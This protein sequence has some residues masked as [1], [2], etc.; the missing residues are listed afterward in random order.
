LTPFIMGVMVQLSCER[1]PQYRFR[2]DALKEYVVG[3]LHAGPAGSWQDLQS[4]RA[5]LRTDESIDKLD[6]ELGIG[7]EEIVGACVLAA[8][9]RTENLE[10]MR[11]IADTAFSWTRGWIKVRTIRCTGFH[12]LISQ[13]L[14]G[15]PRST[16]A[17]FGH[18][19]AP[20]RVANPSD[21]WRVWLLCYVS[22]RCSCIRHD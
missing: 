7:P 8:Y 4:S 3:L 9:L 20:E 11:K 21:M 17:E 2:V 12:W 10:E 22:G 14:C 18:F 13:I 15:A 19:V 16:L 5:E 6:P 1:V